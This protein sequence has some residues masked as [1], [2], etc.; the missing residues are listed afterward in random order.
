M[1][2]TVFAFLN[3]LLVLKDRRGLDRNWKANIRHVDFLG[4]FLLV[5]AISTL[6]LSLDKG[7]NDSWTAPLA[8]GNLIASLV[9]FAL[10]L[11][12]E[13]KCSRQAIAPVHLI[14]ARPILSCL[15]CNFF[16]FGA[17]VA[18]TYN[19]PLYWQAVKSVSASSAGLR[20]LPGIVMN[21][22][23]SLFAGLVSLCRNFTIPPLLASFRLV[24]IVAVRSC[25]EHA[26]TASS[27]SAA[28]SSSSLASSQSSCSPP[29]T[30]PA[31]GASGRGWFSTGLVTG[32]VERAHWSL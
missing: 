13:L 30:R 22:C 25:A 4:T 9:F 17:Y 18:L 7:S 12:I 26:A 3:V 31:P 32:L 23:G 8:Y 1:P 29:S 10:F 15:L 5:V 6:Y 14:F 24:L 16:A 21:V 11:I 20:L 28:T 2:I 19:L 27:L